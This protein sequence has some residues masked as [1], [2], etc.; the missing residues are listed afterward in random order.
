M[1]REKKTKNKMSIRKRVFVWSLVVIAMT[2]TVAAG[3][4]APPQVIDKF[5]VEEDFGVR[6]ALA[7]LGSQ[8][9]KNI[10]PSPN[11]DGVLAFRSLRNITFEEA[12]DAILG[13]DFKYEQEGKLIKVYTKDE[14]KKIKEDPDRMVHKVFT[15]YY[16]T[17]QEAQNLITPVLS[18]NAKVQVSSPAEKQITGVSGGGS[19]GGAGGSGGGAQIGGG[20]GGDSLALNDTIVVYDYPENIQK[21]AQL[22]DVLDVRPKQV[23]VEATILSA[24]LTEGMELGVDWNL[25]AGVSLDGTS[26]TQDYVTG[27]TVDRGTEAS[28][29]IAEISSIA[30]GT[31]MET[32]GFATQG[33]R[34]LR[35]GISTGDVRAIITAL[36]TATDTTVLA[37]PKIMTVNKQEGS[38]LI[39]TNLGY[40]SSTSISTGGVATE[41]EVE[42]L[43]TGTQLVFRPYIGD[44]GYVRMDI[45]PKDSSAALNDDG[46]PTENTTQLRTNIVV[47]D[48]ETIVI[49]GLF[50]DVTTATRSQVPLL[51]DIPIIGGLFRGTTDT[52][53]REE[54]IVLLTT[55]IISQPGDAEG[56]ARTDDIRRKR[57]GAKDG[58]QEIG[59]AKIVE[60]NYAKASK[61]YLEGDTVSAMEHLKVSLALRPNYLEAIR[62]KERILAET[63]PDEAEN[64]E[65]IVIDKVEQD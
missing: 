12:M 44:D 34:G 59:R 33:G 45:Y 36:E 24:L 63:D 50:R 38:V 17:A 23:L 29:P 3:S 27:D 60:D 22:L 42:F 43:Q 7:M 5:E 11:V 64:L 46:V 26:A 58:L 49:G 30:N 52:T 53:Q 21:V 19:G 31:P 54:V 48:G 4:A 13:E 1:Y 28:S 18:A 10:V 41:G 61:C 39:G 62:L 56:A 25:M 8:C 37:N 57:F 32:F 47:K 55:H 15:L 40:R 65:R 20:G 6:K 9:Q 51:G 35:I 16:I 2:A 14:Y